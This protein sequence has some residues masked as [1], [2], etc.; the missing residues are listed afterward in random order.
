MTPNRQYIPI[1]VNN[2]YCN[3]IRVAIT[4]TTIQLFD[5]QGMNAENNKYLQAMENYMYEVLAKK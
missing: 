1:N 3:F 4:N 5:S 2:T